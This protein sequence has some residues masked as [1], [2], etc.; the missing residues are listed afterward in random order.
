[1]TNAK[2]K[3]WTTKEEDPTAKL[4]Y[5]CFATWVQEPCGVRHASQNPASEFIA[6]QSYLGYRRDEPKKRCFKRRRGRKTGGYDSPLCA[7][8]GGSG[9]V[10]V[11]VSRIGSSSVWL[12]GRIPTSTSPLKELEA[13]HAMLSR[14]DTGITATYHFITQAMVATKSFLVSVNHDGRTL[15]VALTSQVPTAP[16]YLNA[17][18]WIIG[19]TRGRCTPFNHDE[20]CE[21]E[22]S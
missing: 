16:V 21:R 10:D 9:Y 13:E 8:E 22:L 4:S 18:G 19:G 2:H 1:M 6:N 12:E 20:E 17:G 7:L 14:R 15:L 3:G 5:P 11:R